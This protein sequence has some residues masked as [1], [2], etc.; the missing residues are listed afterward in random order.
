MV[1]AAGFKRG[2]GLV[3]GGGRRCWVAAEGCGTR[4]RG[5][6]EG[7]RGSLTPA[8]GLGP[9]WRP[10]PFASPSW[11]LG[12]LGVRGVLVVGVLGVPVV[13]VL[14]VPVVGAT[15][16]VCHHSGTS[17]GV[18]G[19]TDI[20]RVPTE[21]PEQNERFRPAS[22]PCIGHGHRLAPNLYPRPGQFATQ[23]SEPL[24][25][26]WA[27]ISMA[28]GTSTGCAL[29]TLDG[30]AEPKLDTCAQSLPPWT[31]CSKGL[32]LPQVLSTLPVLLLPLPCTPYHVPLP[33]TIRAST[34]L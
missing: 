8:H 21:V 5:P 26:P 22:E 19:S 31:A 23:P 28:L 12:V 13:G 11:V 17:I 16:T 24:C 3:G 9:V 20:G 30:N 29:A 14:G 18:S 25:P 34:D 27:S 7:P 32:R 33:S 15:G 6:H 1:R 10:V 2:H 4:R